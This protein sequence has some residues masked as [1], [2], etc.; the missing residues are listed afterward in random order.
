MTEEQRYLMA[1][2]GAIVTYKDI[3]GTEKKLLSRG[4]I[5]LV[6]WRKDTSSLPDFPVV[7]LQVEFEAEDGAILRLPVDAF[8]LPG[9][10]LLSVEKENI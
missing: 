8:R 6:K 7:S 4:A 9:V 5:G 10:E 2:K 3:Q 1:L